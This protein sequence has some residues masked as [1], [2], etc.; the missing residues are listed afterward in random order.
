VFDNNNEL[1][2]N[3]VIAFIQKTI[4]D[5]NIL[6]LTITNTTITTITKNNGTIT[7][8][9]QF[10]SS[11]LTD[12]IDIVIQYNQESYSN[13]KSTKFSIENFTLPIGG[14][15]SKLKEFGIHYQAA[16]IYSFAELIQ[17][18]FFSPELASWLDEEL[19]N[20]SSFI[21]SN[22]PTKNYS[23]S[24][25][26]FLKSLIQHRQSLSDIKTTVVEE[27]THLALQLDRVNSMVTPRLQIPSSIGSI[28]KQECDLFAV[29]L[30]TAEEAE[31]FSLLKDKGIQA[32]GQLTHKYNSLASF[33]EHLTG[34]SPQI[35]SVLAQGID[36]IINVDNAEFNIISIKQLYI[37]NG[38]IR[39]NT[40]WEHATDAKKVV[41]GPCA[42]YH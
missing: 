4:P 38:K 23:P 11:D 37:S 14:K 3:P 21:I 27:K 33:P 31:E 42:I 22:S 29:L 28:T 10:K 40:I 2:T 30:G 13:K 8:S 35:N 7:V 25:N 17:K 41:F 34:I 39:F 20:N 15:I 24:E 26:D 5:V 32:I 9:H 16:H 1:L 19:L 12:A 6:E 36:Y 18:Q